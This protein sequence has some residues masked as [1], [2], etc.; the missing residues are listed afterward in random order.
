MP[1]IAQ[2]SARRLPFRWMI[3]G[4]GVV[5]NLAAVVAVTRALVVEGALVRRTAAL[6]VALRGVFTDTLPVQAAIDLLPTRAFDP[7]PGSVVP[8]L[9][10]GEPSTSHAWLNNPTPGNRA[11]PP[12]KWGMSPAPARTGRRGMLWPGLL[13]RRVIHV[14]PPQRGARRCVGGPLN[15]FVLRP[16]AGTFLFMAILEGGCIRPT[17]GSPTRRMR[18]RRVVGAAAQ[19]GWSGCSARMPCFCISRYSVTRETASSRAVMPM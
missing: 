15:R 1:A 8:V 6:L 4:T 11:Q 2:R 18:R 5:A 3:E 10:D 17:T 16:P 12:R 9:P 19:A 14:T 13:S 7:S